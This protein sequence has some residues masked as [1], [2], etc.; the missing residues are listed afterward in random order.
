MLFIQ[1]LAAEDGTAAFHADK[2]EAALRMLI[3]DPALGE[4]WLI[5]RDGSEA[6]YLV[7]T[8]GFSLEFHGRDA[9]VDE[10]YV[11]P[12]LRGM[13]LGRLAID[14]AAERCRARGIEALHLEVDP[15]N[16]RAVSL[17]CR[18]GFRERTYRL[19]SRRLSQ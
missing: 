18:S 12:E 15:E 10:L 14:H 4:A 13:G 5:D 8:W 2:A 9:F 11:V 1:A 16:D 19:M 7:V 17:Y 3:A 6:G